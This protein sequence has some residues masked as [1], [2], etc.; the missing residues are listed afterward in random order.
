MRRTATIINGTVRLQLTN[1]RNKRPE[2]NGRRYWFCSPHRS[3]AIT[4]QLTPL[5]KPADQAGG[6]VNA[7]RSDKAITLSPVSEASSIGGRGA[8]N[9]EAFRRMIALERKRSERSRKPFML[10]L[11]EMGGDRPSERN[12]KI[13]TNIWSALP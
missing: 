11:V 5:K 13:L 1:P 9:E 12:G 10:M 3:P 8:L 6:I 2:A 7:G 4:S